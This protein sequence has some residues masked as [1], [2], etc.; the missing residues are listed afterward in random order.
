MRRFVSAGSVAAYVRAY[1]AP[2]EAVKLYQSNFTAGPFPVQC[3]ASDEAEY[4][5]FLYKLSGDQGQ[6]LKDFDALK[7]LNL[8]VFWERSNNVVDMPEVA[9]ATSANFV[10]TLRWMQTQ[11]SLEN[12][13]TVRAF[14]ETL[15]N[16]N[17]KRLV[18][19]VYTSAKGV[20]DTKLQGEAKALVQE[21]LKSNAFLKDKASWTLD[22]KFVV[23]ASV[24]DGFYAEFGGVTVTTIAQ[25]RGEEVQADEGEKDY[26]N[27]QAMKSVM[28]TVF[29][30][31][32]ETDVLR[33]YFDQLALLDEEE[34][35][36]AL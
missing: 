36:L 19:T 30:D 23:D 25:V 24:R 16:A 2:A 18:A 26:T 33:K 10:F 6:Y 20:A 13:E 17:K 4:A 14:Y 1:T 8:P 3:A 31:N 5:Q 21:T 15:V 9:K 11:G 27:V 28:K 22:F 12:L 7:K 29:A 32:I 34:Q 35:K